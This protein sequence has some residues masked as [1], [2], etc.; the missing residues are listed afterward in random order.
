MT[1]GA[2]D[3]WGKPGLRALVKTGAAALGV[4]LSDAAVELLLCYGRELTRWNERVNLTAIT[5]PQAVITKHFLDAL[6]AL[7]YLPAGAVPLVDV[8]TGGGLPGL[9]LK[10]ARPELELVLLESVG[11]KA[12]FLRRAVEALGL[13]GVRVY[14]GRAEEAGR[15]PELRE[16]F[17]VGTARAVAAL[18]VSAELVL[19]LVQ[20]GGLFIAFKGPAVQEE[21][22]AAARAFSVLGGKVEAVREL[23]L[24]GG[25]G[26]RA[27]VLV[28]KVA[29]TPAAYP[30]AAGRP[31]KRPL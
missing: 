28:R 1:T 5:E 22:E 9:A 16:G 8:G 3:V 6:S 30:R 19:P 23:A 7:P 31:A 12:E 14:Q 2:G 4:D 21:V 17:A 25:A 15:D 29:P 18:P 26:R 11:K 24:P 10:L 13:S 27:L 20:V